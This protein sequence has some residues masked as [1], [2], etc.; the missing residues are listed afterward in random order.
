MGALP[1]H[2]PKSAKLP[3]LE[4]P[5]GELFEY[6]WLNRLQQRITGSFFA[7]IAS[8]EPSGTL[9]EDICLTRR[10]TLCF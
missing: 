8:N 7:L 1:T 5:A 6:S 10:D 3:F 9:I 4:D 2:H